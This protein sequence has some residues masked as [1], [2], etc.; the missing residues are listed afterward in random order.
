MIGWVGTV[1][2]QEHKRISKLQQEKKKSKQ[3]ERTLTR[4]SR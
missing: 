2:G 4:W 3:T 1:V